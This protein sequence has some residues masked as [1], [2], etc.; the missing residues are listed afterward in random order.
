[1]AAAMHRGATDK[2]QYCNRSFEVHEWKFYRAWLILKD[3]KL[4]HPPQPKEAIEIPDED[5]EEENPSSEDSPSADDDVPTSGTDDAGNLT[6]PV[7]LFTS[8]ASKNSRGPGAGRAKT[9]SKTVEA[10]YRSKKAKTMDTMVSLQAHRAKSFTRFV[11]NDARAKA[12][13]MAALGYSTF[14]DDPQEAARYKNIMSD[15]MGQGTEVEDSE[16]ANVTLDRR[17]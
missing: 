14:K 10:E 5:D 3:H 9:K 11:N 6:T 4:F 12:F 8:T 17:S 1:M 7:S 16:D 15:I 13:Q 2:M